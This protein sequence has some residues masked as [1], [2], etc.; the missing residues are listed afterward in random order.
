MTVALALA[1]TPLPSL[2]PS[3]IPE[4]TVGL[5]ATLIPVTEEAVA[6]M[7]MQLDEELGV[8]AQAYQEMTK[9]ADAFEARTAALDDVYVPTHVHMNGCYTTLSPLNAQSTRIHVY[10]RAHHTHTRIHTCCV[11]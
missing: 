11:S 4:P 2:V 3:W 10:T 1:P 6:A 7:R 9:K 8:L 5:A